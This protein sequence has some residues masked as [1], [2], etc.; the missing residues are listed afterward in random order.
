MVAMAS[1]LRGTGIVQPAMLVQVVT[2]VLN[3]VL[4]PVLIAGWGTGYKMGV[5]GA[6]LAS[7]IAIVVGLL[8]LAVYFHRLEKYVGFDRRQWAPRWDVWGNLLRVGLPAGG[9]FALMFLFMAVM[10]WILRRFGA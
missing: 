10:Y 9:E 6:G 2:V 8:M 1:A 7:S 3:A 5:A 4:A